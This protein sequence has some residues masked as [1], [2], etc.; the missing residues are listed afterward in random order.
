MTKSTHTPEYQL[1]VEILTDTRRKAGLT[2]QQV[3]DRLGKP[4]SY[5]AKAEGS[6]RRID[7]V[8]FAKLSA[9]MDQ[10][11]TAL[12]QLLLTRMEEQGVPL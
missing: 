5:V 3:A 1:L 7:V 9:A 12:L 11:P 4:Q 10:D 6:E 2:Q 8:E